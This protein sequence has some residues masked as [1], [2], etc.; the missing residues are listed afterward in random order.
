MSYIY[1]PYHSVKELIDHFRNSNM[2]NFAVNPMQQNPA[3]NFVLVNPE[4]YYGSY[5]G[6]LCDAVIR[7]FENYCVSE[8][9]GNDLSLVW[10]NSLPIFVGDICA[11]A[12]ED[13]VAVTPS[14]F[15]KM[16]LDTIRKPK[17]RKSSYYVDRAW[18]IKTESDSY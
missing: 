3:P 11:L 12:F 10:W 4:L 6:L 15:S 2:T 7:E 1:V 14:M 13:R 8:T 18:R 5:G 17:S 9:L 16:Q